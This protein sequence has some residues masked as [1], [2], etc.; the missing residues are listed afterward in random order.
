MVALFISR[1][2]WLATHVRPSAF[3]ISCDLDLNSISAAL[4]GNES[5]FLLGTKICDFQ[6]VVASGQIL[7]KEHLEMSLFVKHVA[8]K[9]Q[10]PAFLW[11]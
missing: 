2:L 3:Y 9:Q 1:L 7:V 8:D 4:S 10:F 5:G 11:R 6:E